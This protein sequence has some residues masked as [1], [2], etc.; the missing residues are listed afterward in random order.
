MCV[1]VEGGGVGIENEGGRK[2]RY[3]EEKQRQ[4]EEE[5]GI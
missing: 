1:C 4:S 3:N 5:N 2:E